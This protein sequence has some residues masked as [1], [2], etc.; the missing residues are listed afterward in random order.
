MKRGETAE[1]IVPAD[2]AF[3]KAGQI[4]GS[5]QIIDRHLEPFFCPFNGIL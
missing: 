2:F 1:L 4:L 5:H 3:G